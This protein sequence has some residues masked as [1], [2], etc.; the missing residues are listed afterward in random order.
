[1]FSYLKGL[2][3]STLESLGLWGKK[4]TILFLGLDNAGKTTLMELLRTGKLRQNMPTHHATSEE[5]TMEGITFR[6]I[7]MGGHKSARVLWKN[8]YSSIDGIVYVVDAADESRLEESLVEFNKILLDSDV[9]T[10]PICILANKIDMPSALSEPQFQRAFGLHRAP[11]PRIRVFMC[12]LVEKCGYG[13]GFKWLAQ[14][15]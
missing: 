5:M 8:F 15:I 13:D 14:Q 9:S 10:V 1:M 11:D 7:D 12:S 4:A 3:W 2:F 6:T